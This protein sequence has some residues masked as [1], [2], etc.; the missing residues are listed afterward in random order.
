MRTISRRDALKSAVTAGIAGSVTGLP[1]GAFAQ[2]TGSLAEAAGAKG[3]LFGSA[4]NDNGLADPE[5]S[6]V[7]AR[8]CSIVVGENSFKWKALRPRQDKF[9][10][11]RADKLFAFAEQH[12]MAVRG[13]TLLWHRSLP[14][15]FE[16]AAT[17][18]NIGDLLVEHIQTVAG[19]YAGRLH[20]WDVVNESTQPG[21]G[22]RDGLRE[23]IFLKWM[24]EDYIKLA[25]EA[26]AEAD[27]NAMLA[28]NDFWLP[29]S[30]SDEVKRKKAIPRLLERALSRGAPIHAF[31]LQGHLWAGRND[32]DERGMRNMLSEI[33]DMGLKIMITE[34]DVRDQK[35]PSPDRVRDVY[36]ADAYRRFMDVALEQPA[37]IA[38][39]TWGLSD[40]YT[41]LSG[42][43]PRDDGLPVRVLPYDSDMQRKPIVWNAFNDAFA[44]AKPR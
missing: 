18:A 4:I 29:Y 30:W 25:F 7:A 35:L 3:V 13:H 6:E 23:S 12:G 27:P 36:V 17:K 31:G 1:T 34:M 15:W 32:F 16:T 33:A 37:T 43:F 8:E 39:L 28:Y 41:W 44:A 19:N 5:F 14:D 10:F 22:R 20:S 2:N 24:G 38:I 40:R 42:S 26:A 11:D 9:Y 21:H